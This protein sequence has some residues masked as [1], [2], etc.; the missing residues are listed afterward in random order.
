VALRHYVDPT[1]AAFD[2]ASVWMLPESGALMTQKAAQQETAGICNELKKSE[3][4]NDIQGDSAIND[5]LVPL[6]AIPCKSAKREC[7]GIEPTESVVHT[8]RWF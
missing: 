6:D 4:T 7:M 5:I 1:E 3:E 2:K 8:P